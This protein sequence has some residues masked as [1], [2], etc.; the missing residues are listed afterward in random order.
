M[1]TRRGNRWAISNK[2]VDSLK[3][4][5][6]LNNLES[7]TSPTFADNFKPKDLQNPDY[8]VII[9]L[10]DTTQIN[11][12]AYL[13]SSKVIIH[14]SQNPDSYFEGNKELDLKLF[15]SPKRFVKK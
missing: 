12:D 7:V 14:S 2:V 6:L 5:E 9:D 10:N 11:I 15:L 13:D 1:L 8:K 3:A 4:E